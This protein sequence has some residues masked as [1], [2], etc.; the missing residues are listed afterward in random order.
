MRAYVTIRVSLGWEAGCIM[1]LERLAA[2]DERMMD[3]LR[4]RRT[5]HP[6]Q[7]TPNVFTSPPRLWARAPLEFHC[8][9]VSSLHRDSA[10]ETLLVSAWP[11]AGSQR[12]N[13]AGASSMVGSHAATTP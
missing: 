4:P 6:W 1:C 9:S 7:G 2:H 10:S 3:H 8:D 12:T 11:S 13:H 5:A